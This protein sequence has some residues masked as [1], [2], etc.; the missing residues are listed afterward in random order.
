MSTPLAF[1]KFV[2]LTLLFLAATA[3]TR[4]ELARQIRFG[5]V[6]VVD[7]SPDQTRIALAD[8]TGIQVLDVKTGKRLLFLAGHRD[9][10]ESVAFSHDGRRL[11]SGG[12]D[13]VARVW[14]AATGKELLTL[15]GHKALVHNAI[16]SADD[17]RIL[18][19]SWDRTVKLWDAADGKCLKTFAGGHTSIVEYATFS[20]DEKQILSCGYDNT[21]VIW[22]AASGAIL[23]RLLS[24]T[25]GIQTAFFSRDGR[26][27]L[28]GSF[29]RTA[30]LWDAETGRV[31]RTFRGH[32][33]SI[34][35]AYFSPDCRRMVT[36]SWDR[37]ARVW[38][39]ATGKLLFTLRHDHYVLHSIFSPDG[40]WILTGSYD[41]S[42]ALWDAATGALVKRFNAG[43]DVSRAGT[44]A[45][46]GKSIAVGL[47]NRNAIVIDPKKPFSWD[48]TLIGH[49]GP[50]NAVAYSPDGKRI[51]TGS[52]DKTARIWKA[53]SAKSLKTL[54]GHTGAVRAVAFSPDGIL[55]ATGSDDKTARVW[56][57]ATGKL[58]FDFGGHG[59]AVRTVAFSRDGRRLLTGSD[60]GTLRLW[61]LA[62]GRLIRSIDVQ[63]KV[64]SVAFSPDGRRA[65]VGTLAHQPQ[66][67]D[68]ADGRLLRTLWGHSGPVR[69]VAFAPDG[70]T[71]LTASDDRSI[72]V[73]DA[74]SATEVYRETCDGPV[75]DASYFADSRS[76]LAV[77]ENA[78]A[79]VNIA[80]E[81]P[82]PILTRAQKVR[83]LALA[84]TA[85]LGLLAAATAGLGLLA[86]RQRRR[87]GNPGFNPGAAAGQL[88]NNKR[89][90]F[91]AAALMI[92]LAIAWPALEVGLRVLCTFTYRGQLKSQPSAT[93]SQQYAPVQLP[94]LLTL[95]PDP[96]IG[97]K[98]R[99]GAKGYF[100]DAAVQINAQGFRDDPVEA[101]KP[102]RT[103][104]VLGLG[105]STMFGFGA[106]QRDVYMSLLEA[107]C[108]NLMQPDWRIEFINTGTPG[109]NTSQ[110][111][112]LLVQRGLALEPDAVLVQ[113][114]QNDIQTIMTLPKPD[115]LFARRLL[116]AHIPE[117]LSGGGTDARAFYFL[118]QDDRLRNPVF[119]WTGWTAIETAFRDMARLCHERNIPI[120]GL[121]VFEDSPPIAPP[122]LPL[123][124]IHQRVLDLW[125]EIGITPIQALPAARQYLLENHRSWLDVVNSQEDRYHPNRVGHA[126]IAR[127]ALPP[128]EETLVKKAGFEAEAAARLAPRGN[129]IL[130]QVTMD[131]MYWAESLGGDPVNWTGRRGR[132]Q[133][134][135]AGG[136]VVVPITVGHRDVSTS[137]P[138]KVTLRVAGVAADED[139]RNSRQA[140]VAITARGY[141]EHEVSLTGLTGNPLELSVAV[142]RTF[143]P[144]H[145]NRALGVALHTLKFER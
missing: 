85:F 101:V 69:I 7:M 134:I 71:F 93:P 137:N 9:W 144:D 84:A 79:I 104:R 59:A 53:R 145:D 21:A 62:L 103:L 125:R 82:E 109:Y 135:P 133:F 67:R 99:P 4:A 108:N 43:A 118:G 11:V 141:S 28:T 111:A 17:R 55:V 48:A 97:F 96:K 40:K 68:L 42:L 114:D 98:L 77:T 38:D 66:L 6:V 78:A 45:P 60:D 127:A 100:H 3:P 31:I 88:S 80:H 112:E 51:L 106:H 87:R 36:S 23:M 15:R 120:F 121:L 72:I 102:P 91:Q 41:R 58:L 95:D 57:A 50:V 33:G 131:G 89:A 126:L 128:I 56:N 26:T 22:D 83:I 64:Q 54:R 115:F 29:D 46:D 130:R 32:E 34:H 124:P 132:C 61:D 2:F 70:R 139:P 105:D 107:E 5:E 37:T 63:S 25:G 117:I 142:D 13:A 110:E 81:L 90:W 19:A 18:T 10:V 73:W 143:V 49:R 75:R 52:T 65:L 47:A 12:Y 39:V 86:R 140:V 123:L 138:L 113:F 35:C 20:P 14:D 1:R 116:T 16:F 30:K 92:G 24:H 74:P 27:I 76:V 136:K 122:D 94:Q 44:A 8:S 119:P 129:I